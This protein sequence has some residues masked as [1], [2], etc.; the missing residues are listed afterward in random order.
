MV[1]PYGS[2][3][4]LG[5]FHPSLAYWVHSREIPSLTLHFG[6]GTHATNP[7]LTPWVMGVFSIH[8]EDLEAHDSY[9]ESWA[10]SLSVEKGPHLNPSRWCVVVPITEPLNTSDVLWF[11]LWRRRPLFVLKGWRE[12][13]ALT[14]S[15]NCHKVT[16]NSLPRV[17]LSIGKGRVY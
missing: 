17:C 13:Y 11:P 8:R 2:E 1:V 7:W 16:T 4:T 14:I 12:L 6:N 15:S 5:R 3:C 10:P 9:L